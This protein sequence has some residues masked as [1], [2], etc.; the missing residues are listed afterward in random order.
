MWSRSRSGWA[1]LHA[2]CLVGACGPAGHGGGAEDPVG[3]GGGGSVTVVFVDASGEGGDAAVGPI[4]EPGASLCV[5]EGTWG[6]CSS[7]GLEVAQTGACAQS[8]ICDPGTGAC[9]V[10]ICEPGETQCVGLRKYRVC[11]ELGLNWEPVQPSC[12]LESICWEGAC[13]LCAPGARFCPDDDTSAVCEDSGEAFRDPTSCEAGTACHP[14]GGACLEPICE[15]GGIECTSGLSFHHCLSS[16]TG[17]DSESLSCP[18]DF[19]C[20]EGQCIY[21]PCL[22]TV[23]LLVDRSGSMVDNWPEVKD[24]VRNVVAGNPEAQFGLMSFPFDGKCGVL[25]A[26][27]I[28]I[29]THDPDLFDAWFDLHVPEGATPLT[30]AMFGVLTSADIVFGAY[31]GA[32]ILLSDGGETCDQNDV[33]SDLMALTDGLLEDKGIQTWVIGYKFTGDPVQLTAIA[34]RGGT[35]LGTYIPA[36]SESELTDAFQAVVNDFKQCGSTS[37]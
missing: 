3:D 17:W 21:K 35:E 11:N 13:Q 4:C 10:P 25:Y 31:K 23:L 24:S 12:G 30:E 2:L 28:P 37:D 34:S 8:A 16:G 32:L 33:T 14:F 19:V 9:R 27:E 1:V 22:P 26:P 15:P 20:T 36:G 6:L 7:D 5:D 18:K 29:A